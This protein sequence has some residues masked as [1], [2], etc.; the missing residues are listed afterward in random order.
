MVANIWQKNVPNTGELTGKYPPIQIKTLAYTKHLV[1]MLISPRC[2]DEDKEALK[3]DNKKPYNIFKNKIF[4]SSSLTKNIVS[5]QKH[6][7]ISHT[8]KNFALG[9]QIRDRQTTDS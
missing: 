6:T 1:Q 3:V 4:K 9:Q 2:V 7:V 5:L 8:N